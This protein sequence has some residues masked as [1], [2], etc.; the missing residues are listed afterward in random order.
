MFHLCI[1]EA[2]FINPALAKQY[3][4]YSEMFSVFLKTNSRNWKVTSYDIYNN[5]FPSNIDF[6][7]GFLITGS[8]FGVYENYKW[9]IQTIRIINNILDKNKQIVGI[10]FGHQIIAQAISGL[11]EKS[12]NGWGVGIKEIKFHKQKPWFHNKI[13]N[14]RLISFHQD[15]VIKIPDYADHLGGNSFCKYYSF[16]VENFVFT[17]QGHPEFSKKY[18]LDLLHLRRKSIGKERY[19][20]SK[21]ELQSQ[22]NDGKLVGNLIANFLEKNF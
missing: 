18:A 12:N 1:I 10:C 14:L 20:T 5:N 7:D 3:P 21:Q 2:G 17:L 19:L 11:V 22:A 6:Y 16:G 13:D 8:S 4:S 15:Q 9:I